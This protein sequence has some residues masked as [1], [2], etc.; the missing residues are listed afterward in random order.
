MTKKSTQKI[1]IQERCR[2]KALDAFS[3]I[4][5]Q[6]DRY[7]DAPYGSDWK[8]LKYLNKLGYSSMVV[9]YMK[10]QLDNDIAEVENKEGCEQLEEAYSHFSKKEKENREKCQ[11][12]C[13]VVFSFCRMS[14]KFLEMF[15]KFRY[16]K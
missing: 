10:G 6:I 9:K 7:M 5:Y 1:S 2:N 3:D 15:S 13:A 4:E 11:P 12:K 14:A 8:C 16:T